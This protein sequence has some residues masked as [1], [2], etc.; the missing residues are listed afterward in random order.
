MSVAARVAETAAAHELHLRVVDVPLRVLTND[1]EVWRRLR[2]YYDPWVVAQTGAPRATVRIVQGTAVKE[3]EFTDVAR[4]HG[5]PVKEAVRESGG[6]R[7]IL[8]RETGVL[9]GLAPGEAFAVG[10]L[11]R[12]L[13]QAINLI[14]N[15][16]AKA[17]LDRGHV[18][19]HA[20]A[21]SWSGRAA[22]LAGPPGAGKSTAALHLVEAGFS[23]LSNDR[24][25]ARP[26]EHGVEVLGY[27]KQPRVNPGTLLGHPRLAALL[28]ADD[29]AALAR[30]DPRDLW[31]LERKCDV[32]L[33]RIYGRG[34]TRLRGDL[35]VLMLLRWTRGGS[36][37]AA[38]RLTAAGALSAVPSIHKDLG[39]FDL[40]RPFGAGRDWDPR[41]Y[42]ALF[43]QL[44]VV[45]VTGGVDFRALVGIVGDLLAVEGVPRT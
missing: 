12:N 27:P 1:L 16:Y 6:V 33:E 30:L 31:D 23:F 45:E 9:M 3:G 11:R 18:L 20:S 37:L 4:E 7:L 13:N 5:R 40:D 44:P 10:D 43:D 36:G 15:C 29:R 25:L 26:G 22:A 21:V 2:L 38:R 32:D 8:K 41:R 24:A 34:T 14:N 42:R 39:V 17:V 19:L 28:D 35:R